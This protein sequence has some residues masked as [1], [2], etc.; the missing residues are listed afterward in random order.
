MFSYHS[1][2]AISEKGLA[3]VASPQLA[4]SVILKLDLNGSP[5][6]APPFGVARVLHKLFCYR[7]ES[8]NECLPL[9]SLLDRLLGSL[10]RRKLRKRLGSGCHSTARLFSDFEVDLTASPCLAMRW[11]LGALAI[12]CVCLSRL[13]REL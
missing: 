13:Q 1:A 9:D 4:Y 6:L 5:R 3:A 7:R 8:P 11:V 12:F 10:D 2:G